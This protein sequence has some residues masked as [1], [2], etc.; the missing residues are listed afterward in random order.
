LGDQGNLLD[1]EFERF[2]EILY[3]KILGFEAGP[4]TGL[5]SFLP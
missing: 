1:P 3:I 5:A 4:I 2:P